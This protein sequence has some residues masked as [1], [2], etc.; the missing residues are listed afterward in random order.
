MGSPGSGAEGCSAVSWLPAV[1]AAGPVHPSR[2]REGREPRV[3]SLPAFQA[4]IRRPGVERGQ[5]PNMAAQV[6]LSLA[7]CEADGL[8]SRK[9]RRRQHGGS[10]GVSPQ[11]GFLRQ[12]SLAA[13]PFAAFSPASDLQLATGITVPPRPRFSLLPVLGWARRSR[14]LPPNKCVALPPASCFPGGAPCL[15]T[16]GSR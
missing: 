1:A 3:P 4:P 14:H 13:A 11:R 8:G 12:A 2:R 9:W 15:C 5:A 6:L 10:K 7:P 16:C